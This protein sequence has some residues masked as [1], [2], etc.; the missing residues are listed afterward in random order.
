MATIE[1]PPPASAYKSPY[2]PETRAALARDDAR[3]ATEWASED[4]YQVG[5]GMAASARRAADKT[6]LEA[7]G[8]ALDDAA[9]R[10]RRQAERTAIV[11]SAFARAE[12]RYLAA[13]EAYRALLAEQTGQGVDDLERRLAA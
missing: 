5:L 9:I 8:E 1:L 2:S 11:P 12:R 6:P 10:F 7:A 4:A 13:R 3:R